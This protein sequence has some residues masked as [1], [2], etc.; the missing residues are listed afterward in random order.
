MLYYRYE[1]GSIDIRDA[2]FYREYQPA[3]FIFIMRSVGL[4]PTQ[5]NAHYPLKVACLPVPPRPHIYLL[6]KFY[7]F[8]PVEGVLG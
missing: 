7:F 8:F 1:N 3:H 5:A 6:L 2:T 4:E